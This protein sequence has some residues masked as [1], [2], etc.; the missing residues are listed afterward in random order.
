MDFD[1]AQH[2]AI[3]HARSAIAGVTCISTVSS[4]REEMKAFCAVKKRWKGWSSGRKFSADVC[5]SIWVVEIRKGMKS[6]TKSAMERPREIGF[7]MMRL[8]GKMSSKR[9]T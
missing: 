5:G 9:R 1:Q 3:M 6:T 2:G 4:S 7:L 8:N